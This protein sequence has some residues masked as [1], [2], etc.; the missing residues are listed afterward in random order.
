MR[1]VAIIFASLVVP[2]MRL[3]A[4]LMLRRS[5]RFGGVPCQHQRFCGT[6]QVG[7]PWR[8]GDSGRYRLV[9]FLPASSVIFRSSPTTP[10]DTPLINRPHVYQYMPASHERGVKTIVYLLPLAPEAS[11][12]PSATP[13]SAVNIQKSLRQKRLQHC[14]EGNGYRRRVF[15]VRLPSVIS[16]APDCRLAKWA[17][18]SPST[19]SPR[20]PASKVP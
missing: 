13:G 8:R 7:G 1:P 15:R 11:S 19:Y 3:L 18:E 20:Q 5:F 2:E 17:H 10:A 16:S 9:P 12:A 6:D 4:R 14:R